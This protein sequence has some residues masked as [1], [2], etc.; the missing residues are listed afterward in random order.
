MLHLT[1][2]RMVEHKEE[3]APQS[4]AIRIESKVI[5]GAAIWAADCCARS[6]HSLNDSLLLFSDNVLLLNFHF[7]SI[8][9]SSSTAAFQILILLSEPY[10]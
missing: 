8:D 10:I 7:F 6:W 4:T 3:D 1:A 5:T 2:E 9:E